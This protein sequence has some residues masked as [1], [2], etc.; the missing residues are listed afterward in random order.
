MDSIPHPHLKPLM[1]PMLSTLGLATRPIPSPAPDPWALLYLYYSCKA[2]LFTG[3]PRTEREAM[4]LANLVIHRGYSSQVDTKN[5]F[6]HPQLNFPDG[7][8]LEKRTKWGDNL[9]SMPP[10]IAH[11]SVGC[12]AKSICSINHNWTSILDPGT[13]LFADDTE[14]KRTHSLTLGSSQIKR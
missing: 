8:S 14:M 5:R 4:P 12:C 2:L 13:V 11:P 3:L 7:S 6:S 1:S 10:N 9:L